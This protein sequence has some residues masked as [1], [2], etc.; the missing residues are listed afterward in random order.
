MTTNSDLSSQSPLF[1]NPLYVQLLIDWGDEALSGLNEL[2]GTMQE[3]MELLHAIALPSFVKWQYV[4][5]HSNHSIEE[6]SR[7]FADSWRR[8]IEGLGS[9]T[10]GR[11]LWKPHQKFGGQATHDITTLFTIMF[12]TPNPNADMLTICKWLD[13]LPLKAGRGPLTWNYEDVHFK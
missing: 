13:E 6:Q 3:V 5:N 9:T 12:C 1:L 7:E 11:M 8:L 2:N 4:M 10:F